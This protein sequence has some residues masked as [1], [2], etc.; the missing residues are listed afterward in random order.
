VS[1]ITK[2]KDNSEK[3]TSRRKFLSWI[4]ASL[5]AFAAALV[6]VPVVSFVLAPVLRSQKEVWRAVGA[7]ENFKIG[8]TVEVSFDHAESTPWAGD[9]ARTAAWLQ[10]NGQ[11]EFVAF[12][13]DCT[14]LGCPIRWVAESQLFMC[15]C[16]GGVY[17]KD[18]KVAAGPPPRPLSRYPVRLR[19]GQVEVK[20]APLPIA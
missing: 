7:I 12:S 17:Y 20:T 1:N 8:S 13:I 14:H 19:N 15:P 16:H 9:F 4:G 2:S 6:G 5:S 11:E 18:G 10:R 3:L